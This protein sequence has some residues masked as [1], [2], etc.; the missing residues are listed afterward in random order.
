MMPTGM[1]VLLGLG[2]GAVAIAGGI[3]PRE[4]SS[5]ARA[6][7]DALRARTVEAQRRSACASKHARDLMDQWSA[8]EQVARRQEGRS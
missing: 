1:L 7:A 3:N 2:V 4:E 5:T 6:R 8:A